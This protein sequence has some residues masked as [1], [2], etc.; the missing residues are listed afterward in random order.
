MAAAMMTIMSNAYRAPYNNHYN[1]P[2]HAGHPLY[3]NSGAPGA[4]ASDPALPVSSATPLLS[5]AVV[6]THSSAP[7]AYETRPATSDAPRYAGSMAV[8][9]NSTPGAYA[10]QL[11]PN[12]PMAAVYAQLEEDSK[13]QAEREIQMK[14]EVEAQVRKDYREKTEAAKT[15]YAARV[16]LAFTPKPTGM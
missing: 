9:T 2:Y 6:A 16:L 3:N 15:S 14:A 4:Y 11:A 5:G 7:S 8:A 10:E 12:D 13:K 1:N